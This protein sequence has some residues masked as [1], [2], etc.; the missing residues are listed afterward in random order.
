[1]MKKASVGIFERR[2]F[3]LDHLLT[4]F[5]SKLHICSD[6]HSMTL[7]SFHMTCIMQKKSKHHKIL[8]A[9]ATDHEEKRNN[10][11]NNSMTGL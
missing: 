4:N 2:R 6:A 7:H 3:R 5:V 9:Q 1:M 10:S 8:S 11:R